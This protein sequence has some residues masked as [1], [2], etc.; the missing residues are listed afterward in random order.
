MSETNRQR[1]GRIFGSI[2]NGMSGTSRG[3]FQQYKTQI[4]YKGNASQRTLE[5]RNRGQNT[6]AGSAVANRRDALIARYGNDPRI[7]RAADNII[8]KSYIYT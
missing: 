2:G 1:A 6:G 5:Y 7:Q 3:N 8:S 4:K